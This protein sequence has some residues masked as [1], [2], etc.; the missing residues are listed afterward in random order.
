[1]FILIYSGLDLKYL[2]KFKDMNEI[3][4]VLQTNEIGYD[5]VVSPTVIITDHAYDRAKKKIWMEA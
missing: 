1:M 5:N 4:D 3:Q 2:I